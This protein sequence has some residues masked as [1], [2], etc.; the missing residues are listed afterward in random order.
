MARAHRFIGRTRYLEEIAIRTMTSAGDTP[1]L[2]HL[3]NTDP[4]TKAAMDEAVAAI[5]SAGNGMENPTRVS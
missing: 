1:A 5:D 2:A 4:V 3:R